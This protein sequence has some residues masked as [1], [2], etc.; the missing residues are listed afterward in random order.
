MILINLSERCFCTVVL[1]PYFDRRRDGAHKRSPPLFLST[2]FRFGSRLLPRFSLLPTGIGV[3]F[4]HARGENF[5]LLAK[6][7]L[8]HNSILVNDEGHHAGRQVFRRIGHESETFGHL[9]VYDVIFRAAGAV[10]SLTGQDV[11]I[12]AAVCSRSAVLAFD[13][14]LSSGRRYQWP[15]GAL[16]FA[17]NCFPVK[18]VVL[19]F[20]TQ[21]FLGVLVMVRGIVFLFT[22]HE[23]PANANCR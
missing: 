8:I 19:A 5:G 6:I 10:F 17:L 4:L 11:V 1:P 22:S 3:V 16:G 2:G 23:L 9:S 7:L 13:I 18:A 20:I 12:V 14:A 21:D 15:H